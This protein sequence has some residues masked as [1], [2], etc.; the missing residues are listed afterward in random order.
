[1]DG[2]WL[3]ILAV[4]FSSI[5]GAG[6]L[7]PLINLTIINYF[8]H[9]TYLTGNHA[10]TAMFGVKSNIALAGVLFCYQHLFRPDSWNPRGLSRLHSGC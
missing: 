8:E 1:M 5:F 4:N 6:V 3:F 9:S 10:H 7:E 2:V